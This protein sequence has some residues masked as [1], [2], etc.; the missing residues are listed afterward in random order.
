[1]HDV[2]SLFTLGFSRRH[3]VQLT[4]GVLILA[5]DKLCLSYH[6]INKGPKLT[7]E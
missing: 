5:T 6:T 1:M 7:K 4:P 2:A 3:T